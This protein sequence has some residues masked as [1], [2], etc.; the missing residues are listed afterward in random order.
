MTRLLVHLYALCNSVKGHIINKTNNNNKKLIS[1]I[2]T[3]LAQGSLF[4]LTP[5]RSETMLVRE[6][7][8]F[9]GFCDITDPDQSRKQ[10]CEDV[11]ERGAI[12]IHMLI[13]SNKFLLSND[14]RSSSV[15]AA[16]P[17]LVSALL[18]DS[19]QRVGLLMSAT[20]NYRGIA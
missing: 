20:D 10:S 9:V 2:K 4:I 18:S 3:L 19:Y 6:L 8:R 13:D 7:F 1:S 16:L 17:L 14:W 12:I 15:V 11:D 5:T